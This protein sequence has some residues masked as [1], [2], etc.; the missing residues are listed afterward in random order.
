MIVIS[1]CK[2]LVKAKNHT[3]KN[4]NGEK[5]Q[6]NINV[7]HFNM[8]AVAVWQGKCVLLIISLCLVHR[9]YFNGSSVPKNKIS[10]GLVSKLD[11]RLTIQIIS[12]MLFVSTNRDPKQG[13]R[14]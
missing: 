11:S 12:P 8:A 2:I 7:F 13:R 14:Q 9:P 3:Y 6:M 1:L 5:C 10:W 4:K